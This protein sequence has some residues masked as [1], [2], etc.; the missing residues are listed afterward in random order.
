MGLHSATSARSNMKN[1]I[2]TLKREVSTATLVL[3]STCGMSGKTHAYIVQR[4]HR[5]ETIPMTEMRSFEISSWSPDTIDVKLNLT[6]FL[7]AAY[8]AD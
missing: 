5:V 4:E 2:G 3:E 6:R 1:E 7:T 8:S